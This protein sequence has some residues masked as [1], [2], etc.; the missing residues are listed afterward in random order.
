MKKLIALLISALII[1]RISLFLNSPL[2]LT[3]TRH[4][5]SY[6][7]G[8]AASLLVKKLNHQ[9]KISSPFLF[10]VLLFI[11]P[12]STRLQAGIY[13][14]SQ[15]TPMALLRKLSEG[16]V[17]TEEFVL[18]DGMRFQD[19]VNK[20]TQSP[21]LNHDK[22]LPLKFAKSIKKPLN[23][24]EG[25]LLA[26][27]F[28]YKAGSDA[29]DIL[30]R[31]HAE[32]MRF[33]NDVWAKRAP[34]LPYKTPYELLIAA[35]IIEKEASYYDER[36]LVSAV[37][38]NRLKKNMPLQMDPTVIY[39]LGEAYQKQLSKKDLKINNPYNTY[40]HRGLPPTPIAIVGRDSLLAAANPVDIDY[41]YF[42]AK[43]D[44]RHQFSRT[45][46]E[47]NNAIK[48]YRRVA[49][50]IKKTKVEH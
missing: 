31:S 40:K 25:M 38:R 46:K 1:L 6:H 22:A 35:S 39:A 29:L 3:N 50:Q 44:G 5:V 15:E 17:I 2:L 16:D 13:Q 14:I 37:I 24:V 4:V 23:Q 28:R 36:R 47:Q 19:V 42:V 20:L 34:Q 43:G 41:L 45:L 9:A 27:T 10:R 33:L 12:L 8:E 26:E 30:K 11:S 7:Q 21:Y 48:L 49:K 32:L 18:V